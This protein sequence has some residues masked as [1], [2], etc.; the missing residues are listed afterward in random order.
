MLCMGGTGSHH[1]IDFVA[2]KFISSWKYPVK[3]AMGGTGFHD[4]ID[5]E[6]LMVI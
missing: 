1:H 6:A 2:L 4:L 5:Y 3:S